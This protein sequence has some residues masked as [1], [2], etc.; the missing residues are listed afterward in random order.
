[1]EYYLIMKRYIFIL[2]L[3]F[4]QSCLKP[5]EVENKSHVVKSMG[6]TVAKQ[7]S[8]IPHLSIEQM[9]S[10]EK[11]TYILVDI[12][13][14]PE[15]EISYIPNSLTQKKFEQELP[16]FQGKKVIVYSTLGPRS[17][18]YVR[19]LREKKIDAYNLKE[20]ILGW[21]HRKLPLLENGKET[22]RLHVYTD[23]YNFTPSG[24]EGV[25]K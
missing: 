20:G 17:S 4:L 1:M 14:L 18:K 25:Y 8:D 15:I 24:Y 22:L 19:L 9:Q 3:L 12:R 7:Y 16:N 21:A 5:D 11:D 2:S 6:E 23:A 13:S 10:L